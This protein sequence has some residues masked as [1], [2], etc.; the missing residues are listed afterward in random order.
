[1]GD[2]VVEGIDEVVFVAQDIEDAHVG[3]QGHVLGLTPLMMTVMPRDSRSSAMSARVW[4][5]VAS[6]IPNCDMRMMT[7][8]TSG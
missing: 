2:R 1:M 4:A 5:P 3:Q 7:T 8:D 6:T